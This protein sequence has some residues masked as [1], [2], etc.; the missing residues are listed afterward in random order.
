MTAVLRELLSLTAAAV[1]MFS[2]TLS[3]TAPQND[4]AGNLFLVNR[5]WRVS[6][7]YV[8]VVVEADVRGQVR[9]MQP[10]AA[11]A[12]EKMFAACHR[13]MPDVTLVSVSG[14]RSYGKQSSIYQ[15]K[16]NNV[17]GS[18][19]R[20]DKYVARPGASEHQLGLAMDVGQMK[21]KT[22]LN[23]SFGSTKGGKWLREHCWEYGF[24]LRYDEGWEDVTGYSYEPWHV[25]YVGPEFAK[26]I[27]LENV[28]LEIFL[29]E[30]RQET[31]LQVLK[32]K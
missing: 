16:L 10:D 7:D 6:K 1:M 18:R 27:H 3:T 15:R 25:R 11:A 28:P 23:A 19:A 29:D 20:A 4:L 30:Y 17:S 5:E 21:S 12:L 22:G 24:I 26:R 31:L 32:G 9:N 8:P 13:E 2:E 14:Y